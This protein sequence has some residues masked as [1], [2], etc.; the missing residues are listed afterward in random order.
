MQEINLR[1]KIL[2]FLGL[3]KNRI[4]T[5]NFHES[6]YNHLIIVPKEVA[7]AMSNNRLVTLYE[8]QLKKRT[9]DI[10]VLSK[11][12]LEFESLHQVTN[13]LR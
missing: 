13:L 7:Q 11:K 3:P 2:E 8:F 5:P 12:Y 4:L 6:F 10:R 1:Q 9:A